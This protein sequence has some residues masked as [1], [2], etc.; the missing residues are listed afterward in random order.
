ML[1]PEILV[2]ERAEIGEGPSWDSDNDLLY[3]V[4]IPK[5]RIFVYNPYTNHNRMIDLSYNFETVSSVAARKSGGLVFTADRK[6]A[7]INLRTE[8]VAILGEVESDKPGNR[9]NDGKCD[10]AGRFVAGTMKKNPDGRPD[11]TLYIMDA[12]HSIRVL[13]TGL[14]ISNGLGWSPDYTKFYLADSESKEVWKYDYD[15]DKGEIRN[16]QVAFTLPLGMGVADGMTIDAEGMIWLALWDGAQITR[17]NPSTG[18]YLSAYKFPA[19]RTSSCVFGGPDLDE[20]FVTSAATGL[21]E[22]EHLI[23]PYNGSL[24]RYRT[25]YT[26]MPCFAFEG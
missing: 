23:Y 24:M 15:L 1:T 26:G 25:M 17:W 21:D 18:Q 5:A 11:G 16:R 13:E 3:W 4:D 10:P 14:G 22:M 9:F 6:F 20:L 8:G 2:N 7:A 12:D 19:K